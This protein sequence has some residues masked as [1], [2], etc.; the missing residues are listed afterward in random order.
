VATEPLAGGET[1]ERYRL[2]VREIIRWNRRFNL[3]SRVDTERCVGRLLDQSLAAW[4]AVAAARL[5][6]RGP[7]ETERF[8]YADV[9][10]GAGFPGVVWSC[11]L[12]RSG[13]RFG[14]VLVEPRDRRA[15]FLER[16]VSRLRIEHTAVIA[17][18]WG[19]P[20]VEA[21]LAVAAAERDPPEIEAKSVATRRCGLLVSLKALKLDD[22]ALLA[23]LRGTT[24]ERVEFVTVV[25][26]LRTDASTAAGA[27]DGAVAMGP[28]LRLRYDILEGEGPNGVRARI[29][30]TRYARDDG[31]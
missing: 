22:G 18:R 25:R 15:W 1:R 2:L 31:G 23:G 28:W 17:D 10:S 24:V 12:A 6:P 30:V 13:A 26:F 14:S 8:L 21:V 3:V 27:K 9:G 4:R 5:V 19:T 11:E 16:V 29:A 7:E 20:K